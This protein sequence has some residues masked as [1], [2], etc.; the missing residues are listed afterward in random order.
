MMF[1]VIALIPSSLFPLPSSFKLIAQVSQEQTVNNNSFG[2]DIG[3]IA[4]DAAFTAD[5]ASKGFDNL[6]KETLNGHLY[7]SIANV[8]VLFAVGTLL[9]FLIQW[10][11]AMLDSEHCKP[12]SEM[13]WPLVVI[14]LLS[15]HG[16]VLAK[17]TLGLREMIHVTNQ[18]M[19]ETVT[20]SVRLQEAYQT[21]MRLN[22]DIEAIRKLQEQCAQISNLTE[23][24]EC[25]EN[26]Q[27]K[28]DE[29]IKSAQRNI[30][31]RR[32]NVFER[33]KESVGRT[34]RIPQSVIQTLLR[35]VLFNIG[36]AYQWIIEISL[37][38][39]AL[40]GPLAVGGSLLPM[41]NKPIISWLTAMFSI[42]L[43]KLS[44]NMICG[45]VAI[46]MFN[47]AFFDP[48]IF[49][50]IVGFFAPILSVGLAT[51][52]GLSIL[53]GITSIGTL[54]ISS[55]INITKISLLQ[56]SASKDYDEQSEYK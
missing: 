26:S 27:K 29:I 50:I 22:G 28:A 55:L 54:G 35:I 24:K 48:M 23:Q 6:W 45:L 1:D 39:T 2:Q 10:V 21:V 33:L 19:L 30:L 37:L 20:A 12:M 53:N 18:T 9:I 17:A 51:G 52:G 47:S 36:Y 49:P 56:K 14:V 15:G 46:M 44:Y 4:N 16:K 3:D 38:I 31:F 8:G 7:A 43:A 34:L 5:L 25:Y 40:L 13:I 41:V 11:K 32:I 42:G